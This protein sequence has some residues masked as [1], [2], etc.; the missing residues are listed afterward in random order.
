M[1][2]SPL[3]SPLTRAPAF[4][5]RAGANGANLSLDSFAGEPA[6]L[7]FF[8]DVDFV[9]VSTEELD[10]ARAELRGLGAGL[11]ALSHRGLWCFRPD[12][13]ACAFAGAAA[14][15]PPAMAAL[16]ERFGV[17]DGA[18][19]VFVLD[20]DGNI[21]FS[22]TAEGT[23][24]SFAGLVQALSLAGRLLTATPRPPF[25]LTRR[26]LVLNSL[27]AALALA[28]LDGCRARAATPPAARVVTDEVE[29]TLQVN[30]TARKLRVDPRVSLLDAL[31]ERLGLTGT[32]K[33]CDHG[34]CGACT[35]LV[36]GRRVNAC[37][38]LAVV[39]RGRADHDD[40]GARERRTSCTRCR[41]RSSPRTGSSAGTARRGRS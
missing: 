16:R 5:L 10:R 23:D 34:Q 9:A 13:Q 2:A 30:G 11:L 6:V 29:L 25:T 19:A 20:A 37:L 14:L 26:Q 21:R 31:R 41:P 4:A 18:A 27:V 36:D 22:T 32:K 12:E 17:A 3:P 24:A 40:R 8:D 33:G 1:T 38:T 15:D 28:F 39:A 35:V 7:A